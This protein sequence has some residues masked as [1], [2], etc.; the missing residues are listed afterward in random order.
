M[1]YTLNC[2]REKDYGGT[3]Y[4]I[5]VPLDG[6]EALILLADYPENPLDTTLASCRMEFTEYMTLIKCTFDP[7][8]KRLQNA[9]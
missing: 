5:T 4:K 3:N 9:S 1:D 2:R 7:V 6:S 8:P